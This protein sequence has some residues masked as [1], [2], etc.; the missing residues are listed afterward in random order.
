MY[1]KSHGVSDHRGI[2]R[3]PVRIPLTKG[4]LITVNSESIPFHVVVEKRSALISGTPC[5]TWYSPRYFREPHR[6]SMG[7]PEISS[8]LTGMHVIPEIGFSDSD[9]DV[10][11]ETSDYANIRPLKMCVS[12]FVQ[13]IL[14]GR[15]KKEASDISFQHFVQFPLW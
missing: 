11:Q 15:H 8:V 6:F 12:F 2:H 7:L 14:S 9:V 1:I 13:N 4:Q 5:Y 3:R 10:T